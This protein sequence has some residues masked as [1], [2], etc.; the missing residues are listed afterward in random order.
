MKGGVVLRGVSTKSRQ[1]L[2]NNVKYF[3]E[4]AGISQGE[5]AKQLSVDRTSI[6]HYEA[7]TR[8]PALDVLIDLADYF[9]VSLDAL[10][11]HNRH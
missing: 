1:D 5:L 2:G 9:E 3:R 6:V 7:G 4:R 8:A 10:I 11:R